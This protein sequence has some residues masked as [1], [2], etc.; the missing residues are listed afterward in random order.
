MITIIM[1][2]APSEVE[3][4][5]KSLTDMENTYTTNNEN[6]NTVFDEQSLI[7]WDLLTTHK[8]IMIRQALHALDKTAF[9][10]IIM[11][12]Y[13]AISY[14]IRPLNCS[15]KYIKKT[16]MHNIF[17]RKFSKNIKTA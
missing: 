3:P 14:Q 8:S 9:R 12:K 10:H 16:A 15:P 2:I 5:K 13:Q 6:V 7:S 17:G 4:S 11:T 1:M